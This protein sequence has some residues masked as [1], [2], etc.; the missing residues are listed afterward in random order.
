VSRGPVREAFRALDQAG[1]VRVEKNRGVFVRQVSVDEA[2]QIYEVRAALEGLIGK[3][4]ARRIE[5]DELDQL[6]AVV[7]KMASYDTKLRKPEAYFA[8]NVEFHD[9]LARAARNAALLTHYRRVVNELDLYRRETI[10]RSTENIPTSTREHEAIVAA[11]A[12][13]D[14]RLAEKLLTEHVLSSRERLHAALARPAV[15]RPARGE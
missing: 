3:L 5:A 12:R 4:A 9:I 8:L 1:L 10:S 2:D 6:R 15:A 7:K 14:E 13:R 11:V